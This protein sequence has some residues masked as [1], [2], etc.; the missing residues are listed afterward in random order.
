MSTNYL[1]INHKKKAIGGVQYYMET[2]SN[3]FQVKTINITDWSNFF[4]FCINFLKNRNAKLISHSLKYSLFLSIIFK[5]HYLVVHD[6]FHAIKS[7]Y[8]ARS[9]TFL[10]MSIGINTTNAKVV[11]HPTIIAVNK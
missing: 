8:F 1:Q 4:L 11:K 5:N 2:L 9:T 6:N 3:E 7:N 10:I